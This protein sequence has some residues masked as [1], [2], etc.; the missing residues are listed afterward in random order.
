VLLDSPA[1]PFVAQFVAAQR[2]PQ[3]VL[4]GVGG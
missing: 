3:R 1:E 4:L 2:E